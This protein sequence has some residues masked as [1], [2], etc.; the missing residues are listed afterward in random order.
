M[1]KKD[2]DIGDNRTG[3]GSSNEA[4]GSDKGFQKRFQL[5]I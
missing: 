4:T 3:T 5:A 1:K 2:G